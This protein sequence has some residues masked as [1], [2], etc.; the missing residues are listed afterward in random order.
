[1]E[2]AFILDEEKKIKT[3]FVDATERL[4]LL[5]ESY[6]IYD[7]S[8]LVKAFFINKLNKCLPIYCSVSNFSEK[9]TEKSKNFL[10]KNQKRFLIEK[11]AE[12]S[13]LSLQIAKVRG[14]PVETTDK[15]SA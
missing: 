7:S 3:F 12:R 10:P 9:K 1:M 15:K 13:E 8:S 4:N 6:F 2:D 5:Q 11:S 14:K